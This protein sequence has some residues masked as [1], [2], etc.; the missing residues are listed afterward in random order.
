MRL[1]VLFGVFAIVAVLGIFAGCQNLNYVEK[2]FD[3]LELDGILRPVDG[4]D[5]WSLSAA[6][7]VDK[8]SDCVVLRWYVFVNRPDNIPRLSKPCLEKGHGFRVKVKLIVLGGFPT[9]Y[10]NFLAE[11]IEIRV[12]E[13]LECKICRGDND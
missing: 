12:L 10:M 7:L 4:T 11:A 1:T 8:N 9:R 2:R 6:P 3:I 13:D 5:S